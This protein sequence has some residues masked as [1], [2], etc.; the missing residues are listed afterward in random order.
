MGANTLPLLFLLTRSHIERD[1]WQPHPLFLERV[2]PLNPLLAFFP[3]TL[4]I[5][6]EE[7]EPFAKCIP[8]SFRW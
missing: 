3:S 2:S 6:S 7:G 1:A 5:S 8:P 4:F